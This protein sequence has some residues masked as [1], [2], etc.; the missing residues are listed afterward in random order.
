MNNRIQRY[1]NSG[2]A[3]QQ[4]LITRLRALIR[5]LYP[6]AKETVVNNLPT[7]ESGKVKISLG[8]WEGGVRLTITNPLYTAGLETSG[9]QSRINN[10]SIELGTNL[11]DSDLRAAIRRAMEGA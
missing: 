2:S 7:F 11:S 4:A 5:E 1:I 3:E 8:Y 6:K 10:D 9:P